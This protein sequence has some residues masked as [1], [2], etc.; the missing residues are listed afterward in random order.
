MSDKQE[1]Y[2][3]AVEEMIFLARG[4]G[5]PQFE[6]ALETL[7]SARVVVVESKS[8]EKRVRAQVD[9]EPCESWREREIRADALEEAAKIV[10]DNEELADKAGLVGAHVIA[11]KIVQRAAAVRRG[12]A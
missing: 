6:S 9:G 4:A 11:G 8:Q 7:R 12:E 5:A 3:K 10:R 1:Q 2:E